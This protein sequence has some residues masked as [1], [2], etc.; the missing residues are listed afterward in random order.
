MD[1]N[2]SAFALRQS[3]TDYLKGKGCVR[4]PQVETAFRAVPRHLF[5]PDAELESVYR[6]ESFVLKALQDVPVSSSSEPGIMAIMLEQ[7][8]LQP[9]QRVLEIGAGTGYNAAL[10]AHLVGEEGRVVTVEIDEDIAQG[11]RQHL[12]AAGVGTVD[13]VCGDGGFGFPSAGPYDRVIL[14]VASAEILP[15]WREQLKPTGRI[16]LPLAIKASQKSVAFEESGGSLSSTSVA[17]C[18]FMTLRGVF[19]EPLNVLQLRP[20]TGLHL[21]VND[22]ERYDAALVYRLLT[23]P[24]RDWPTGVQATPGEAWAGLN[25]WLALREP[26]LCSLWVMRKLLDGGPVPGLLPIRGRYDW[27]FAYGL[28][29]SESLNVLI[30]QP[31][32]SG[33]LKISNSTSELVV[34]SFGPAQPHSTAQRLIEQVQAWEA[35]GRPA[36]DGLRIRAY[37]PDTECVPTS[38]EIVVQKKWMHLLFDWRKGI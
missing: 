25:F 1:R 26:E 28:L 13:V 30:R 17:D 37:P 23:G 19:S 3:L 20:E 33:A 34:R 12:A 22:G 21:L 36:T 8:D 29:D 35:A 6:D 11:A 14:T 15:P 10:M 5:V 38:S 4:T 32:S 24:Y 9:G 27:S 7:L 16:V 31:H 2:S 18:G